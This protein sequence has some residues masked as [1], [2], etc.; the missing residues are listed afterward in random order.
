MKKKLLCKLLS[1]SAQPV[2]Y[3]PSDLVKWDLTRVAQ[4]L[5]AAANGD[6]N[7]EREVN[8]EK[9]LRREANTKDGLRRRLKRAKEVYDQWMESSDLLTMPLGSARF[10]A[11]SSEK[12]HFAQFG[13]LLEK[14]RA[15]IEHHNEDCPDHCRDLVHCG[16]AMPDVSVCMLSALDASMSNFARVT[17]TDPQPVHDAVSFTDFAG[18]NNFVSITS[19]VN[20]A[21]FLLSGN[22]S[23]S[24]A[25]LI[26]IY[27][28][29]QLIA[30]DENRLLDDMMFDQYALGKPET[31][32]LHRIKLLSTRSQGMKMS[33]SFTRVLQHWC[34]SEHITLQA[35]TRFLKLLHFYKPTITIGDYKGRNSAIPRT[36][37]R[38]LTTSKA[39]QASKG[40]TGVNSK[41]VFAEHQIKPRTIFGPGF[42][43]K[44]QVKTGRYV[45]YG[46]EKAILGT[47]I[48]LH[49]R[50]HYRNLLR[51]IHTVHPSM[52][53]MEFVYLTRPHPEEP[54][55]QEVWLKW[56][57]ETRPVLQKE[58]E[59]I[60]FEIRINADGSQWY[61]SSYIK[62][63]PIF[64]KLVAIRTLSGSIRVKAP[65]KLA[66][67]FVIGV[68][69]QTGPKPLARKLMKDTIE[70][71]NLL[72]PDTLLEGGAR[73][74]SSYAI[75]VTCFDCDAPMRADLK[76]A[77][78]CNGFYGCERCHTKG[79]YVKRN[80][81]GPGQTKF[82]IPQV[83]KQVVQVAEINAEGETTTVQKTVWAVRRPM[84]KNGQGTKRQAKQAAGNEEAQPETTEEPRKKRRKIQSEIGTASQ[85]DSISDDEADSGRDASDEDEDPDVGHDAIPRTAQPGTRA[86]NK[87]KSG[88]KGVKS[89]AV[90]LN[91]RHNLAVISKRKKRALDDDEADC[92]PT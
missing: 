13:P 37:R 51:R 92:Y 45:H 30:Q 81:D 16:Q 23:S 6:E 62:G 43:T 9:S 67:S 38:L 49:Y 66:K 52:L 74:G 5:T 31:Y 32:G 57:M 36:G 80:N 83:T 26:N 18:D 69:E 44:D 40:T 56:L 10:I 25:P 2:Q 54:F 41:S 71:M 70:E 34:V 58:V 11:I 20:S 4:I 1:R 59:P 48:G 14:A 3:K 24:F 46:V 78:S 35:M 28:S 22:S 68:F 39:A 19:A 88:T 86:A 55:N 7:R 29:P 73:A 75:Q 84:M 8:S 79:V 61:E 33:L 60:V 53:P 42:K 89:G 17:V 72:H 47:S 21:D 27:A 77:K 85:D 64:G 63:T 15:V 91:Q 12:S 50:Y 90:R 65:Y 82:K 76:G 87:K